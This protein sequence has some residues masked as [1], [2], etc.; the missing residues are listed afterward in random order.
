MEV[1]GVTAESFLFAGFWQ[2][3]T[4]AEDEVTVDDVT[5]Y[6][7]GCATNDGVIY[8]IVKVLRL[9]PSLADMV[10]TAGAA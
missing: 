7:C 5:R 9:P 1:F 10:D 4:V 6:S 3:V 8:I 2:T